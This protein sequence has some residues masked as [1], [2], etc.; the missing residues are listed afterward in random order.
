[1]DLNNGLKSVKIDDAT[2]NLSGTVLNKSN[3]T[4]KVIS[5][6]LFSFTFTRKME[7]TEARLKII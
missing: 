7:K 5:Q 4:D 2:R 3:M 1:M 6:N